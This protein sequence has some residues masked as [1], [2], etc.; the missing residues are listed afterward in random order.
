MAGYY[1]NKTND[2]K[3]KSNNTYGPNYYNYETKEKL[4]VLYWDG[5]I[6]FII[7]KFSENPDGSINEDTNNAVRVTVKPYT[8]SMLESL[9]EDA[10]DD[11]KNG[12][13]DEFEPA[14]VP[15]GNHMNNM[16]EIS[17]GS[18]IGREPG[19]YLVI[20]KDISEDRKTSNRAIYTFATRVVVK[21]YR[22]DTGEG[23]ATIMK[24]QEFKDFIR[25]M[26]DF[27][28]GMN[29]AMAHSFKEA[30]KY[31]KMATNKVLALICANMGID[32]MSSG[33]YSGG[34]KKRGNVPFNP[35]NSYDDDSTITI[36]SSQYKES[37]YDINIDI[38]DVD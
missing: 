23:K 16:I 28:S 3:R 38:N 33:K 36:D 18:N 9:A 7:S 22:S 31:D 26:R 24:S 30:T 27:N 4:S 29:M 15:C 32:L 6:A 35:T 2:E 25:V 14:G 20:Y 11:I 8:L 10:Y 1:N 12:K 21:G 17:N 34:N 13:Y 19:V 5:S 37:D